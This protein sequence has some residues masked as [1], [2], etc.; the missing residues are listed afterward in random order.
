MREGRGQ[1]ARETL[2]WLR[3]TDYNLNPEMKELEALVTEEKNNSKEGVRELATDRGFI[4][5]LFISCTCFLFQALCGCDTICFYI[6]Y[7]FK[8]K[9]I[10][11][12]YAA[13]IYQVNNLSVEI[14]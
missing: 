8:D 7:M 11:M 3:G 6:G 12:E 1:E 2:Q 5:P 13:I 14:H 4:L 10:R 9:E